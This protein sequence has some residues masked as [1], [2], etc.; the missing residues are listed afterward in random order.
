ML[1][2]AAVTRACEG[3]TGQM[4]TLVRVSQDPYR[5]EPGLAPLEKIAN[6]E[7]PVPDEFISEDGAD[8]TSAFLDYARPLI[9]GPLPRYAR[10]KLARVAKRLES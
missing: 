8:V 7:R 10:L 9:G 3:I 5:C 1:G 2:A 6:A 4:V